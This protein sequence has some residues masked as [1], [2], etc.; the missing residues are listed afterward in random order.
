MLAV[1]VGVS[2]GK[3]PMLATG[4]VVALGYVPLARWVLTRLR[5]LPESLR[6]RFTR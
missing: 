6:P 2:Y 5:Y 3:V 1:F 4:A